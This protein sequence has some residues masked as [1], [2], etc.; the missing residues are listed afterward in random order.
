ML[1]RVLQVMRRFIEYCSSNPEICNDPKTFVLDAMQKHY[2]L[3]QFAVMTRESVFARMSVHMNSIEGFETLADNL[4]MRIEREVAEKLQDMTTRLIRNT[5]AVYESQLSARPSLQTLETISLQALIIL[6]QSHKHFDISLPD[7]AFSPIE[8][9]LQ[10]ILLKINQ[11]VFKIIEEAHGQPPSF[12][13][14]RT[15]MN[16]LE[17]EAATLGYASLATEEFWQEIKTATQ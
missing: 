3:Q 1:I 9:L 7:D 11:A 5:C 17:L 15:H 13:T 8:P 2:N 16:Q 6:Q 10:P 4:Q 12:D 14:L